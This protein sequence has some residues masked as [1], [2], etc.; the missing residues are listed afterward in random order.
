MGLIVF[1]IFYTF[2]F[3][4]RIEKSENKMEYY[5]NIFATIFF[6]ILSFCNI[7]GSRSNV[8]KII[9]TVVIILTIITY[10]GSK[11]KRYKQ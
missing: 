6:G 8:L 11:S 4:A 7:T 5:H 10:I 2:F 1:S 9:G 3:A